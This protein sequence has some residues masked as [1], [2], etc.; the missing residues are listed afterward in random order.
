MLRFRFQGGAPVYF[1]DADAAMER[2]AR[3]LHYIRQL[4]S[5][6]GAG[7]VASGGGGG[8]GLGGGL[9]TGLGRTFVA[10]AESREVVHC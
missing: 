4:R 6:P 7:G 3:V 8:L 2:A 9:M 5:S 10:G 1:A